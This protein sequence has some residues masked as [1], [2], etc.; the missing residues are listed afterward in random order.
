MKLLKFEK[1]GCAPC[2]AMQRHLDNKG[3]EV[4][5]VDVFERPE[6]AAK[7]NIGGVPVLMLVDD[8]GKEVSRVVGFSRDRIDELVQQAA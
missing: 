1:V 2:T 5:K 3:I 7:Y 8:E 6:V 4:E